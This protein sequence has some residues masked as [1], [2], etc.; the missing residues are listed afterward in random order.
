MI[1]GSTTP[2]AADLGTRAWDAVATGVVFCDAAR[3]DFPIVYANP[4][5]TALTGYGAGELAGSSL[6]RLQGAATDPAAAALL[7]S[8]LAGDRSARIRLLTYR[9]LG[10]P[11]WCDLVLSPVRDGAGHVSHL[12]GMIDDVSDRVAEEVELRARSHRDA[13]TGLPNRALFL[14]R[15]AQAVARLRRRPGLVSML[16]LDVDGFKHVNDAYG[17]DAGDRLLME[18]HPRLSAVLRPED[19]LA[20]FGGDEFVVVCEG[21]SS[22]AEARA[23]GRRL[24]E[25]ASEPVR[26]GPDEV[27]VGASV[28]IAISADPAADPVE[29]L[30]EADAAMYEAKSGPPPHVALYDAPMRAA[31]ST[32]QKLEAALRS[33]ITR[34]ELRVHYQPIVALDRHAVVG[35]EALVRWERPGGRLQ[36]P[37][38]FLPAAEAAG[39]IGALGAWVLRQACTDAA[40]WPDHTDEP[41]QLSVNVSPRQ[42]ADPAFPKLVAA[43]LSDT[44]LPPERL[45]I[46][47][48]E[49]A[50]SRDPDAMAPC[51]A[52]LRELGVRTVLDDFGA[53]FASVASLRRLPLD[54][55][56]IDRAH[57]AELDQP[58]DVRL[59]MISG[60]VAIARGMGLT[61][62]AEGIER[63]DHL[64]RVMALGCRRAQGYWFA[65]PMDAD[66][67]A[68]VLSNPDAGAAI[69]GR[70]PGAPAGGAGAAGAL[71]AYHEALLRG[72]TETASGIVEGALAAGASPLAVQTDVIG[73][74]MQW[75]GTLWEQGA[76]SIAD[77]RIATAISERALGLCSAVSRPAA[78]TGPR[79]L[80]AAAEGERHA[81]GLKIVADAFEAEG[82]DVLSLGP[83]VP[84]AALED[85][86]ARERPEAV[87]LGCTLSAHAGGVAD[88]VARIRSVSA[89]THI[90]IGGAGSSAGLAG[91]LG[92]DYAP[93]AAAAVA[94]VRRAVAEPALLPARC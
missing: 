86:V 49:T 92:V 53:G 62:V 61:V 65:A 63:G 14:D 48:S 27:V 59:P 22:D 24:A 93:N 64:T 42:C 5:F 75:I 15:A 79:V 10:E 54:G 44:G 55:I 87:A 73:R 72:D 90:V 40:S 38:T 81:L 26:L 88:A 30:K 56:K 82:F 74:A 91:R 3:P 50:L 12:V 39:M 78:P 41:L 29:L 18:L 32:R 67:A 6:E 25:A 68:R 36:L 4:A 11:F 1:D 76:I 71:P 45:T 33:A 37:A 77:E 16:F 70:D 85:A 47:V 13:L 52:G 57:V 31:A 2:I 43:T 21:L 51:L 28:G 60:L 46:E 69:A 20:R 66:A 58:D 89:D 84:A 94:A 34:G 9:K 83:D 80:V 8:A 17:H 7:R 19:T 23:V 35:A